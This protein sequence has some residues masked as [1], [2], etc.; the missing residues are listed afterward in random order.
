M[1]KNIDLY[2]EIFRLRMS[3]KR[4][5]RRYNKFNKKERDMQGNMYLQYE[6]AGKIMRFFY[7]SEALLCNS[8]TNFQTTCPSEN[9][10]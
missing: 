7:R 8:Y 6:N 9:I 10:K 1:Y 3:E 4:H 2:L 5:S